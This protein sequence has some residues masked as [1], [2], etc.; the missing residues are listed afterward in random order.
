MSLSRRCHN[1]PCRGSCSN[2]GERTF[3]GPSHF[4]TGHLTGPTFKVTN[5]YAGPNGLTAKSPLNP[6]GR[7]SPAP[8]LALD[9]A[10]ALDLSR[11]RTRFHIPAPARFPTV[12]LWLVLMLTATTL[13]TPK[14]R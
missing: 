14:C 1:L 13:L 8:D 11:D 4:L 7:A 10:P 2:P 3:T 6:P 9:L 5:V 12:L